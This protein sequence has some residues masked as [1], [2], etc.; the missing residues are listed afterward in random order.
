MFGLCCATTK[1][2][3]CAFLYLLRW[4]KRPERTKVSKWLTVQCVNQMML[5]CEM[6]LETMW[7]IQCMCICNQCGY[8]FSAS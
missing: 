3:S 2:G 6:R 8:G 1:G 4:Y 5:E 7:C